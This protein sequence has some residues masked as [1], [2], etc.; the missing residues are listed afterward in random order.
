MPLPQPGDHLVSNRTG[1]QHH[2]LYLGDHQVIHYQGGNAGIHS[3]QI[4]I[5]TLAEFSQGRCYRIQHHSARAFNREESIDRA[6]SRL[7]EA[8]Y[9]TLVNNCEH[10]V[11]WCIEGFHYSKQVNQLITTGYI[12]HQALRTVAQQS[13]Q[14]ALPG[15][16]TN[17][18]LNP[19]VTT[20]VTAA[21]GALLGSSA[22]S[23]AAPLAAT[24]GLYRAWRWFRD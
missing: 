6:Y 15:M 17:T 1:Y 23:L 9:S 24:Y 16:A 4:A 8:H 18:A 10:F 22:T 13:T 2:G 14:V 21:A 19:S 5:T 7:G 20:A 12:A 3:G 11:L